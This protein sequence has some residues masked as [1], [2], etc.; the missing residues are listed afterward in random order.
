MLTSQFRIGRRY[1]PIYSSTF[2][3]RACPP[4]RSA[5]FGRHPVALLAGADAPEVF[6]GINP[7]IVA[8]VPI[9]ANGVAAYRL[10]A[11]HGRRG[12][13][14]LK[15]IGRRAM[16]AG[17]PR[18][19]ALV[20]QQPQAV[21]AAVPVLPIDDD[22]LGFR[23]GDVLGVVG[24]WIR[25]SPVIIR[26]CGARLLACRRLSSRRSSTRVRRRAKARRQARSL[27]PQG[28]LSCSAVPRPGR[29]RCGA[30]LRP[31]SRAASC[32]GRPPSSPPF[33]HRGPGPPSPPGSG[34]WCPRRR[35]RR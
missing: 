12:L 5:V 15:R 20:A 4:L 2:R 31:V 19:W 28:S 16:R 29:R 11:E 34:Y 13:V 6:V 18:A 17:A 14:H 33:L 26:R 27:A 25:L 9:D 30:W 24:Q 7:G 8:V 23:N 10:D 1:R 35:A 3:D 21:L 32:P 22:A